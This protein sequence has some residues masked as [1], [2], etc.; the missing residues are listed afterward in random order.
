MHVLTAQLL[1]NIAN[2][3]VRYRQISNSEAGLLLLPLALACAIG[4][5]GAGHIIGR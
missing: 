1:A 3:Y 5:L 2:F 4:A